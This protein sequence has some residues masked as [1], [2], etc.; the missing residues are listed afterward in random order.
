M[1]SVITGKNV[2]LIPIRKED[3]KQLTCIYNEQQYT[4]TVLPLGSV[5]FSP[6]CHNVV[7]RDVDNLTIM[8][9]I[10]L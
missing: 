10:T 3:Q 2:A 4:V 7:Q 6:L 9:T 5:H 8:Q 1:C